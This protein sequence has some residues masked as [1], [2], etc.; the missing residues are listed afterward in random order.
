MQNDREWV[1]RILGEAVIDIWSRLPPDIQHQLFEH[2]VRA[3]QAGESEKLRER[4]AKFLHDHHERTQ[5]AIK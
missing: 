1:S 5:A 2:A 4:L 3:G